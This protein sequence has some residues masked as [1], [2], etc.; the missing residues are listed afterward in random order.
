MSFSLLAAP[1]ILV[2]LLVLLLLPL[3]LIFQVIQ[4]KDT[5]GLL[6]D[7]DSVLYRCDVA[8]GTYVVLFSV[9]IS[10]YKTRVKNHAGIKI[11]FIHGMI[12]RI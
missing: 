12:E 3:P 2:I 7:I 10:P 9:S 8:Y 1:F 6:F 11:F 5:E 4:E